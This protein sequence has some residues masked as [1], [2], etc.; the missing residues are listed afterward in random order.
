M[1]R[2]PI[3]LTLFRN[4]LTQRKFELLIQQFDL[5]LFLFESASKKVFLDRDKK[6]QT[7]FPGGTVLFTIQEKQMQFLVLRIFDLQGAVTEWKDL[8]SEQQYDE[9]LNDGKL[10]S[11][12][13][14]SVARRLGQ[15]GITGVEFVYALTEEVAP[16]YLRLP[17][18]MG[19][20]TSLYLERVWFPAGTEHRLLVGY[21]NDKDAA[22]LVLDKILEA[23][24]IDKNL[25]EKSNVAILFEMLDSGVSV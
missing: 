8:L 11:P 7:E 14:S 24:E 6:L 25:I 12:D 19:P 20:D 9:L 4:I 2:K 23:N 3:P 15:A 22:E 21:Q 1:D 17:S 16:I 10:P 18:D 13:H 5:E